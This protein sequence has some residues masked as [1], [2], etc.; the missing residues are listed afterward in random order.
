MF[1]V[2]K[3]IGLTEN[4]HTHDSEF[5]TNVICFTNFTVL[6]MRW[7]NISNIYFTTNQIRDN[8][9]MLQLYYP[10]SEESSGTLFICEV[11]NQLPSGNIKTSTME[12]VIRT[13]EESE[14]S[15]HNIL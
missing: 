15:F 12:L 4:K 2:F 14:L 7:L 3:A 5:K 8:E 6:S 9:L 11:V 13:S 1:F 10:V